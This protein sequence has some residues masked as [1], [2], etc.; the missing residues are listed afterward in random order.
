MRKNRSAERVDTR[1]RSEKI[2]EGKRIRKEQAKE[3]KI[4]K[5]WGHRSVYEDCPNDPRIDF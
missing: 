2:K 5:K 1:P 4:L 3:A